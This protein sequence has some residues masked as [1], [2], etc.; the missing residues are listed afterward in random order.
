MHPALG[1]WALA[2]AVVPACEAALSHRSALKV[3]SNTAGADRRNS[4][5]RQS[6]LPLSATVDAAVKARSEV[7]KFG[8][9][10]CIS[11]WRNED[12]HC[13]VETHCKDQ[14][15]SKYA[16]KF[17]CIDAG[18]EKVRH[19]FAVGSFD[20]EEEFDT[21]IECKKCLAEKEETIQIMEDDGIPEKAG[22]SSSL[23]K[24]GKKKAEKREEEE[25]A[26]LGGAPLLELRNEV[27]ELEVFMMNTSAAL[28]KLNAVVY[29]DEFKP[30]VLLNKP[31]ANCTK[32]GEKAATKALKASSSLVHHSTAHHHQERSPQRIETEAARVKKE[33]RRRLAEED[34]D[35]EPIRPRK[36]LK[37]AA[38][39]LEDVP[40]SLAGALRTAEDRDHEVPAYQ[41]AK[42][43]MVLSTSAGVQAQKPKALVVALPKAQAEDDDGADDNDDDEESSIPQAAVESEREEKAENKP[44]SILALQRGEDDDGDSSSDEDGLQEADG[45]NE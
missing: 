16:V 39:K 25:E 5:L 40:S 20:P 18:G 19:V 9:G 27:K 13:A 6:K 11:T 14:D 35:A 10:N 32:V 4:L 24:K 21:L 15:I 17:I 42:S 1:L 28:Q 22:N 45:D 3:D 44:P 31:C 41:P 12:G 36:V 23:K 34:G 26:E 8:P 43:P 2:A 30:P 29:N 37:V 38:R 33:H 7:A